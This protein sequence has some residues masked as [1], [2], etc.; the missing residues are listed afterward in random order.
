M[1]QLT[2]K[3]TLGGT[4]YQNHLTQA[5][6]SIDPSSL[7]TGT[8]TLDNKDG[9]YSATFSA[10]NAAKIEG[11]IDGGTSYTTL[12]DGEIMVTRQILTA[13]HED[14]IVIEC[15]GGKSLVSLMISPNQNVLKACNIGEVFTGT[16]TDLNGTAWAADTDS[17]YPN[18]LLYK[19][20]YE[21]DANSVTDLFAGV[22]DIYLATTLTEKY[23]L[24]A[25]KYIA[26]TFGLIF[27]IDDVNS[28][29]LILEDSNIADFPAY[30]FTLEYGDNINYEEIF[31]DGTRTYDKVTLTGKDNAYFYTV[32][33]GAKEIHI[34]D[35]RIIDLQTIINKCG[36][37][38][39]LWNSD[40]AGAVVTS[41]PITDGIIGKKITTTDA[42]RGLA[43]YRNVVSMAHDITSDRWTT[44]VSLESGRRTLSK[45]L[46]EIKEA[47]D[48]EAG[49]RDIGQVYLSGNLKPNATYGANSNVCAMGIGDDD[50]ASA[51]TPKSLKAIKAIGPFLYDAGN[52]KI[53]ANAKFTSADFTGRIKEICVFANDGTDNDAN[54]LA[55]GELDYREQT[56]TF[57]RGA[58]D[59][60]YQ[61]LVD[62]TDSY[63]VKVQTISAENAS[64]ER[65]YT[66]VPIQCTRAITYDSANVTYIPPNESSGFWDKANN[67]ITSP[68]LQRMA[69]DDAYFFSDG[70]AVLGQFCTLFEWDF[71]VPENC[72]AGLEKIIINCVGSG[73]T[74]G[75]AFANMNI[76]IWDYTGSAWVYC[77]AM[78]GAL[79]YEKFEI[80]A[81]LT[82]YLNSDGKMCLALTASD[83]ANESYINIY[84][85]ST[86]L[87]FDM[88]KLNL[89]KEETK[90][91]LIP[92]DTKINAFV[93]PPAEIVTSIIGLYGSA[94]R[95]ASGD[96]VPTGENL[97]KRSDIITDL[98]QNTLYFSQEIQYDSLGNPI[99]VAVSPATSM[100]DVPIIHYP[101]WDYLKEGGNFYIE[102][103]SVVKRSVMMPDVPT[104]SENQYTIGLDAGS[105]VAGDIMILMNESMPAY[106]VELTSKI[107]SVNG[108]MVIR[109]TP[110]AASRIE[111]GICIDHHK[112]INIS[113]TIDTSGTSTGLDDIDGRGVSAP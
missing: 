90:T 82:K 70:R 18:G 12:L 91:D 105:G 28:K 32:G 14:T 47:Q 68:E 60:D 19:S 27:W 48:E 23:I 22:N 108:V 49:R 59:G 6:V 11:S 61:K 111:K 44:R 65:Y 98:K 88:N 75:P 8:I 81:N 87:K 100:F 50:A 37:L 16:A 21:M 40:T 67:T 73:L 104:L 29:F 17:N 34:G 99:N 7:P 30:S 80:V 77:T 66:T 71:G 36:Q 76:Y 109:L 78:N 43:T 97:L 20:G 46:D 42:D 110:A 2:Y 25:M 72:A 9:R 93:F 45:I 106:G 13:N 4:E 69:R 103:K 54:A 58:P 64:N 62:I 96:W 107:T 26:E 101:I 84:Y 56:T 3:I 57:T 102:Y 33:T 51:A 31:V 112:V 95:N 15:R 39:T 35:D 74:A 86:A 89:L 92:Y 41:P 63:P 94:S 79:D 24:A 1:Q 83:A 38:Y 53:Y 5:S 52:S 113:I 10:G 55:D 85:L